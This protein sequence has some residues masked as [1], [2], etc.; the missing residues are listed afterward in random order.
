[1]GKK[2]Y[3]YSPSASKRWMTCPGSLDAPP[4]PD[5]VYSIE[6]DAAHDVLEVALR[7]GEL[8]ASDPEQHAAVTMMVDYVEQLRAE[9]QPYFELIECLREHRTI[10]DLG[11][12][13]DYLAIYIEDGKVVLHFVDYKH[14]AGVGVI[15]VENYQLLTYACIFASYFGVVVDVYRMTIIQPRCSQVEP[16][17]VWDTTPQRVAQHEAEILAVKDKRHFAAGPHCQFCSLAGSCPTLREQSLAV[18]QAAFE[19]AEI[20]EL[21]QLFEMQ[22][23]IRA[24]LNQIEGI[25]IEKA[26]LGCELP[27]YKVVDSIG[28]RKWALDEPKLVRRLAKLGISRKQLFEK[29]MITPAAVEKLLELKPKE[30]K[31]A[32]NGLTV[33]EK[34][35]QRVVPEA[36]RGEQLLL[37][38]D[39]VFS[40]VNNVEFDCI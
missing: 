15:A 16:I 9:K 20:P 38:V 7:T 35:G 10:A 33:R 2:H 1:M 3:F 26:R 25:L 32:L 18:A 40:E 4:S 19:Q 30:R 8:N 36:A 14:G 37:S 17:Q 39:Q 29:R 11:G 31:T 23:A 12:T 34:V 22:D 5:T 13:A 21:I 24:S 28:H 6:G 27:G